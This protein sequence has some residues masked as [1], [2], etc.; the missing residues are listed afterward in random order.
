MPKKQIK[1]F[2]DK[3]ENAFSEQM[4]KTLGAQ[5]SA[6]IDFIG[7]ISRRTIR[8]SVPT[9]KYFLFALHCNCKLHLARSTDFCLHEQGIIS[10]FDCRTGKKARNG[11]DI[12]TTIISTEICPDL[13]KISVSLEKTFA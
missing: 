6:I 1:R 11:L 13:P 12:V 3:Y 4:A 5:F 9:H 10:R 2:Y 7:N 8:I